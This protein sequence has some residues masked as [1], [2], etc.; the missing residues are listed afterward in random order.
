M[1]TQPQ[2]DPR[3]K[4]QIKEALYAHLYDPVQRHFKDRL[5]RLIIKNTLLVKSSHRSFN[6]KGVTY[7]CDAST[8]PRRANKLAPQLKGAM[9]EY[10]Q[11]LKKLNDEE[12]PYVIGYINQVLNASNDFCDYLDL[13]P[14]VVHPT[15][16]EFVSKCPCRTRHLTPEEVVSLQRK[17]AE[18]IELLKSRMVLNLLI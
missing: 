13:L 2:H 3:T 16:Q 10:L 18:S 12:V 1:D 8:P 5:D 17:N 14:S 6:Y 7:S 15:I 4:Q 11:D 9:D